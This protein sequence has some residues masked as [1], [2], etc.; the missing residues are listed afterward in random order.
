MMLERQSTTVPN[1]ATSKACTSGLAVIGRSPRIIIETVAW[2]RRTDHAALRSTEQAHCTG[3]SGSRCTPLDRSGRRIYTPAPHHCMAAMDPL[4]RTLPVSHTRMESCRRL[5]AVFAEDANAQSVVGLNDKVLRASGIS[6]SKDWAILDYG[7]GSGRH[8]YEYLDKGYAYVQG[9]DIGDFVVP[10]KDDDLARFRFGSIDADGRMSPLPWP[11]DTFDFVFAASVFEHVRDQA[12]AYAEIHRVLKPGGA[13]LN[14]FPS[15][16]RPL[17][18]HTHIPFGGATQARWWFYL[19]SALGVRRRE[20]G[21][22]LSRLERARLYSDFARTG[23]CYLNGREIDKLMAQTFGR[24]RYVEDAFVQYS[25]GR[26]RHLR[27]AF[28]ALPALRRL[29]R[30]LHTRI[31]LAQKSG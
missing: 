14:M 22:N 25:P 18:P 20:F 8:V 1:T 26:S 16:W 17:E 27:G 5:A 11:R 4:W 9:Y 13:F 3:V 7:C 2:L 28:A 15:K 24:Y 23:V 19:W 29:F 6:P 31:I 10:R 30:A 21:G 12:T